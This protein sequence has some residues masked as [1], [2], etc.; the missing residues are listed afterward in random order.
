MLQTRLQSVVFTAMMVFVMAFSI[1]LY[2][3]A[4]NSGKLEY[5]MFWAALGS[6]WLP[7]SFAVLYELAIA[8]PLSVKLV[9]RVVN[10]AGKHLFKALAMA[11]SM[12]TIMCSTM[13]LFI[14]FMVHEIDGELPVKWLSLFAKNYPFALCMQLFVAGPLVRFLFRSIF[15]RNKV[16]AGSEPV[17]EK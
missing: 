7:Y 5:T 2:N 12:V 10:P 3:I 9:F 15:W 17:K 13:S 11:I 6:M 4:G 8:K 1:S 14:T 16:E